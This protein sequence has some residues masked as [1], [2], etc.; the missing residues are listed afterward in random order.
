MEPGRHIHHLHQRIR[1]SYPISTGQKIYSIVVIPLAVLFAALV[2]I[3]LF[4][5]RFPNLPAISTID[6]QSL[7]LA[8]FATFV[9]LLIAYVLSLLLAIPL[10]LLVS[11]NAWT[12]RVFLPFFDV[13][14]SIPVLA[15]FPVVILFFVKLN[16]FDGAAIFIL[17][18]SMLWNIVFSVVGG[19]KT[20]P[21]D[22]KNAA[23]VFGVRKIKYIREV[24]LPS[25]VPHIVTG[26]LLAWAQGWNIIIVAEVIHTYLPGGMPSQDLYGIGSILVNA[27]ASGQNNL[28][29]LSLLLMIGAIAI[30]NFFVWQKLLRYAERYRF[31]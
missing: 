10:A 26:S 30:L 19:L 18:L 25:V 24:L 11:E 2:V 3:T 9:R 20:I 8:L 17:F 31:E 12:E 15:F 1:V 14:Q 5:S 23:I 27:I 16:F 13:V 29:F 21:Q 22:I 4:S 7:A 28:F 6:Y